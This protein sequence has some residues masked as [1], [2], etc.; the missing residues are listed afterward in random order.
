MQSGPLPLYFPTQILFIL[1]SIVLFTLLR[2]NFLCDFTYTKQYAHYQLNATC[3]AE[4]Q[5]FLCNTLYNTCY[6]PHT[7]I[8]PSMTRNG[9]RGDDDDEL[10][11]AATF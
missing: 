5:L 3:T 6:G 11:G 1:A 9:D 8:A 2:T 4:L 7:L 10:R